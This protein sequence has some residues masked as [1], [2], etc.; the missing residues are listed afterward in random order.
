MPDI[1]IA[2]RSHYEGASSPIDI[3]NFLSVQKGNNLFVNEIGDK[4]RGPLDMNNNKIINVVEP[5]ELKDV[6]TKFYVDNAIKEER[7]SINRGFLDNKG[8]IRSDKL[9]PVTKFQYEYTLNIGESSVS[10]K[11]S[12]VQIPLSFDKWKKF[13]GSPKYPK[14]TNQMI[15]LQITAVLNTKSYHDEIFMSIQNYDITKDGLDVYVLSHR[16]NTTGWGLHLHAHL[17]VTIN[18]D[19]ILTINCI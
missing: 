5:T 9:L 4:M 16:P 10:F 15:N 7:R 19:S 2:G 18:F 3:S 11:L 17:L 6:S 13:D 1:D 14:L 12:K 8:L